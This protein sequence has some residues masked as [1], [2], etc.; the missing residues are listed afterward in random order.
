MASET[1]F[2]SILGYGYVGSALNILDAGG[3]VICRVNSSA[4]LPTIRCEW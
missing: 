2:H 3:T 1:L 4:Q